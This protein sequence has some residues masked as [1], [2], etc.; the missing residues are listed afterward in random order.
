MSS[1]QPPPQQPTSA[2]AVPITATVTDPDGVASVALRYQIVSPGTYIRKTDAAFSA[3]ANWITLPMLDD[4]TSGDAIA[5]DAIFTALI[6]PSVQVHR[7]LIRYQI[8]VTDTLTNSVRVPYADDEQ[9]NFAYF[10][11]DALPPWSG[12]LRPT[13]FSGFPATPV[14]DFPRSLLQSRHQSQAPRLVGPLRS[15]LISSVV[16]ADSRRHPASHSF[17]ARTN[18]ASSRVTS[19]SRSMVRSITEVSDAI[20]VAGSARIARVTSM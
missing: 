7:R 20:A 16:A 11:Y 18:R 8:T 1:T 19:S 5:G 14:Q 3:A 13:T 17:R 10:V 6:P 9:P 4:G 12:A 15:R 2:T